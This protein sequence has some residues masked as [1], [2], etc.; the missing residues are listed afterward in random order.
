MI[1]QDCF[2]G[3][4]F[5]SISTKV[6]IEKLDMNRLPAIDLGEL[7]DNFCLCIMNI[8]VLSFYYLKYLDFILIQFLLDIRQG[9]K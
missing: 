8:K 9:K 5:Y 7:L 6:A 1:L 4:W 3:N 2:T